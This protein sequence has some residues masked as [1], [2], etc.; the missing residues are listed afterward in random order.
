NRL[1]FITGRAPI[2]VDYAPGA[3]EIIEQHDGS[4]LALR[5]L[6]PDYDPHDRLAATAYLQER[7]AQ[8]EIVTGLL[9]VEPEAEDLHG[10]LDTVD[11][12]LNALG[13]AELCPG[14][15]A[16]AKLNASLR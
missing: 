2:T 16:L 15:A 9:F 6:A 14:S 12:P 4:K 3:V 5:K 10:H 1:D 11:A 8:G 13:E 7:A